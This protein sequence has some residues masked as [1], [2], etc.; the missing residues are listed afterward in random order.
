MQ[1]LGCLAS[2]ELKISQFCHS[3]LKS[4]SFKFIFTKLQYND[5]RKARRRLGALKVLYSKL[6][7]RRRGRTV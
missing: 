7:V 2:G 6:T 5:S 1:N 4:E 3:K